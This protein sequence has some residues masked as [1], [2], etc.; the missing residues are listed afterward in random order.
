MLSQRSGACEW[1]QK[2]NGGRLKRQ[3]LFAANNFRKT[4]FSA[5]V[6]PDQAH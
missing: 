3:Q 4:V 2:E 6:C 1:E 5:P